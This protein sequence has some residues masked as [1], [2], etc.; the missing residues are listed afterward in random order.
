MSALRIIQCWVALML[1]YAFSFL[2]FLL[3]AACYSADFVAGKDYELINS[4]EPANHS[5]GV[6]DVTEFFSFGCPWCYRLEP[7]L[8]QWL[9]KNKNNIQF[10]KM[11]VIFNKDWEIYAKTFFIAKAMSMNETL[12]P[13]LFKAI[14]TDKQKLNT[15]D[16]MIHFLSQHG[17]EESITKGAFTHSPSIDLDVSQ[18]QMLMARYHINAVPAFVVNDKFKTDLQMAKTEERMFAILDYLITKSSGK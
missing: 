12:N 17:I 1:K 11:P 16:A 18:S 4:T 13:A 9:E 10:K 14:L 7:A 2:L 6:I 3:S 15:Q 8:L 5:P